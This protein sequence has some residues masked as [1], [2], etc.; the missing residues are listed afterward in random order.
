MEALTAIGYSASDSLKAVRKVE[1]AD[2]MNVED[3]LK[4]ALK[5]I[6]F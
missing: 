1:A 5:Y 3:I 6:S 2:G 4:A